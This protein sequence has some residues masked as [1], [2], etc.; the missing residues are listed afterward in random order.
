MVDRKWG[1]ARGT[2]KV[3]TGAKGHTTE[4]YRRWLNQEC[5][6]LEERRSNLQKAL[7]ELNK[8]LA[9]AMTKQK[10]FTTMIENLTA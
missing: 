1:L 5:D 10:S 8:E 7:D 4:S 2:S 6:S 3:L 9:T